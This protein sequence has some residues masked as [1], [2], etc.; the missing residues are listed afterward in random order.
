M[1]R[2][3]ARPK[4]RHTNSKRRATLLAV[5]IVLQALCALFF[6]F[7]VIFDLIEGGGLDDIHL[8]AEALAA[9][10]LVFGTVLLMLELRDLLNRMRAMNAG[11]MAARGEMASLMES[12][13]S[14]WGLTPSERDIARFILKG[15]DNETI[16][17][18]RNT[19]KGTVRA[20]T[21]GIYAKAQVD[22]RAQFLS[23]FMEELFTDSSD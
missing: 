17:R 13:F 18:L 4:G 9:I 11:L 3:D 7:D 10:V 12:A 23:L 8:I 16:A 21:A 6:A 2:S 19:A 5:I 22:G 15:L 20:Q 1:T 14:D